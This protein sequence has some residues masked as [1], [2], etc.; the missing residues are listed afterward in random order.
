MRSASRWNS[1]QQLSDIVR[2]SSSLSNKSYI[3]RNHEVFSRLHYPGHRRHCLGRPSPQAQHPVAEEP[4]QGRRRADHIHHKRE[5][6][7]VDQSQG[8][9]PVL[10]YGS[11][12]TSLDLLL[13]HILADLDINA[14]SI[15][16]SVGLLC[17]LYDSTCTSTP[18]CCSEV[19][20]LVSSTPPV[21]TKMKY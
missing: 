3:C 4:S 11:L 13:D 12:T 20:L 6:S 2:L 14:G 19:N 8:I 17:K 15:V 10:C 21:Q 5:H 18:Q 1:A 9:A 7:T 16:G